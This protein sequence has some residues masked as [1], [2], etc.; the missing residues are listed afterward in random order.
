MEDNS[1]I[2]ESALAWLTRH[3]T[4][5]CWPFSAR[6]LHLEGEGGLMSQGLVSSQ[7][8]KMGKNLEGEILSHIKRRHLGSLWRG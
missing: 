7:G 2:P 4:S 8:T 3:R 1:S 6:G 5:K